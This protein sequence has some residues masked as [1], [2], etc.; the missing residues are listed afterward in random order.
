MDVQ[1]LDSELSVD[2]DVSTDLLTEDLFENSQLVGTNTISEKLEETAVLEL[3]DAEEATHVA[4]KSGSWFDPSTWQN[5]EVPGANARIVIPEG[6]AVDYDSVSTA[7]LFSL[8]VDGEISFSPE[9]DTQMVIDTFVISPLGSLNIGSENNPIQSG[10]STKIII[11]DNGPIDTLWDPNQLS[12]GVISLGAVNIHGQLKTPF[13]PIEMAPA[14]GDSSLVLEAIPEDWQVGDVLVIAASRQAGTTETEEESVTIQAIA[15]NRITLDRPLQFDHAPDTEALE[16]YVANISR[17]VVIETENA[18]SLPVHQRGHVLLAANDN[19]DVRFAEFRELGRTDYSKPFDSTLIDQGDRTNIPGRYALQLNQ[20]GNPDADSPAILMGNSIV[21]SPGLG[22][23]QF[24]SHAVLEGNAAY[25]VIGAGFVAGTDQESGSWLNNIALK[26]ET[27]YSDPLAQ[28]SIANVAADFW[29]QG[30]IAS[31]GNISVESPLESGTTSVEPAL[32]TASLANSTVNSSVNVTEPLSSAAIQPAVMSMQATVD[33]LDARN[34]EMWEFEEW[35]LNNSTYSGNPF[36]LKAS[37]TFTHTQSGE[38][39]TTNMFY[40]GG[41]EWSFRFTGDLA[42]EWRFETDSADKDLDGFTGKINVSPNDNPEVDGFLTSV[43]NKFALQTDDANT[44]E[45]YLLN[46]YMN[47]ADH[48]KQGE[49]TKWDPSRTDDYLADARNNGSEV[50][51]FQVNNNWFDFGSEKNSEHNSRNPDERTFELL[52][53]VITDVHQQGGRVHFW[54]WGD[55][56]RGWTPIDGVNSEADQRLQS[57]IAARLGPL[58]GWSMGYSFDTQEFTDDND[59]EFWADN[60]LS[61]MGWDHLLF[62]RGYAASSDVPVND[63]TSKNDWV[64]ENLSGHSYSS[65]GKYQ[66]GLQTSPV[67]PENIEEVIEDINTETSKPHF[68]EE[69]F[70]YNRSSVGST[71]GGPNDMDQTRQLMWWQAMAG[72]VGGWFGFFDW[73]GNE[74]PPYSNPEQLRTHYTFWHENDRFTLDLE[75]ANN[76]ADSSDTHLLKTADDSR[77]IVYTENRDSVQVD[78]PQLVDDSKVIAVDTKK[79]YREIDLGAIAEGNNRQIELPYRSDWAIVIE[80]ETRSGGGSTPV[81]PPEVPI[82]PPEEPEVPETPDEPEVPEVP[83]TPTLPSEDPILWWTLDEGSGSNADDASGNNRDG[84][85]SSGADWT[86]EGQINGALRLDGN[87]Q[88]VINADAEDYLNGLDAITVSMWVKSD[89]VGSDRGFLSTVDKVGDDKDLGIR[90]DDR[91]S[92]GGGD[93]V[94]K[95]GLRTTEGFVEYESASNV[96]T[97]A[98]QHIVLSWNSGEAPKLYINGQLDNPTYA[99]PAIGGTLS[100]ITDLIVGKGQRVEES[101]D[102]NIDDVRIYNR[103]VSAA[104]VMGLFNDEGAPANRVPV[105]AADTY[106]ATAGEPLTVSAEEGVLT[107]DTDA[108]GDALSISNSAT[109]SD[110]G[111]NVA[112]NADGSF[113]YTPPADF[114][115]DDSFDYTVSDGKGGSQTAQVTVEVAAASVPEDPGTPEEPGTPEPPMPPIAEPIL[116]WTLDEG[117]GSNADDASGNNRDGAVSSG[118]DWTAEGQINGALRLDGNQQL[119]INADAEDYLNGLDAITVSMWVKSDQVG[120]DRGFLSTVDKVGDDKDLGIRYDDRG[121][122][123]GGDDVIKLGLRTTEGFVEYES[124]SNVQTQAWQHIV[125]SWNSG[126]APKL[127]INGQLDNPT[128]AAP[129]IGGTLS[130]ITDLIVGKGQR[131]EES[132]DGNIDDVRIY[133]RAVN[134]EEAVELFNLGDMALLP[135]TPPVDEPSEP[136]DPTTP[137]L[138]DDPDFISSLERK[139]RTKDLDALQ[140][141]YNVAFDE[142][143]KPDIHVGMAAEDVVLLKVQQNEMTGTAREKS[144][145]VEE[146]FDFDLTKNNIE[147]VGPNGQTFRPTAVH[148]KTK[149]ADSAKSYKGFIVDHYFHIELP[150]ALDADQEYT[151]RFTEGNLETINFTPEENVS[152]AIHHARVYD[153]STE[154]KF[155]KLSS[156]MSTDGGGVDYEEGTPYRVIDEATGQVVHSGGIT[157]DAADNFAGTDVYTLDLSSVKEIGTYRIEVEGIGKSLPFEVR[158]NVWEDMLDLTMEGLYVHRAFAE[159]EEPYTD[160]VRPGNPDIV[161]YPSSVSEVDFDFFDAG[162]EFEVLPATADRS[163]P[164]KLTGGWFD[165]GDYDTKSV[166]LEAVMSLVDLYNSAP[167]YFQSFDPNIPESGDHIPD[168]LNEAMWGMQLYKQLQQPHGGVSAGYEFDSHPSGTRSW[169]E[170]EAFIYAPDFRS[171]YRFAAA[172]SKLSTAL[173]PF[174]AAEAADLR[175]RAIRAF[176]WAEQEFAKLPASFEYQGKADGY[177][178]FASV[179]MYRLTGDKDY[180]DIFRSVDEQRNYRAS[181]VYAQL[182]PEVYTAVDEEWQDRLHQRIIE[183]ADKLVRYGEENGF[184][185]INDHNHT[186]NWGYNTVITNVHSLYMGMAHQLTGDAKYLNALADS[187]PFG[188]GMNPDN[189]SFTT[190]TVELGLAYDEVDDVLHDDGQAMDHIPDGITVYGFYGNGWFAW[191]TVNGAT[192]NVVFN[193]ETKTL[194]VPFIEAFNDYRMM[195]PMTEYTIHQTIDEQIYANGYLAAHAADQPTPARTSDAL[196][197]MAMSAQIAGDTDTDDLLTNYAGATESLEETGMEPS[198]GGNFSMLEST[199]NISDVDAIALT[200]IGNNSGEESEDSTFGDGLTA[201]TGTS[202]LEVDPMPQSVAV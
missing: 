112:L 64:A 2:M 131:V 156:W 197:G 78:L 57:Y 103:A 14:A 186:Q 169:E 51:Y 68:Y 98:W 85:V 41:N 44:L 42:G 73:D 59:M 23:V 187:M 43:G 126:E 4:V 7:P 105:A 170:V 125:L 12:R 91:G 40:D 123:G 82:D 124:A 140:E 135:E 145:F 90:Y 46:V 202:P 132:W 100:G 183:H 92:Y 191:E 184:D 95:L 127:Y 134:A 18:G 67:S 16:T 148:R 54:A 200:S 53:Q 83:E 149:I 201:V 143:G 160:F 162:K 180:H 138:D 177:R 155:A 81:P 94:I 6:I 120:S 21:G 161:F 175:E 13:L 72:G 189:M 60:L 39:R 172:A 29:P 99:A 165:A 146:S 113:E 199:T 101:W 147:I 111:G 36:D 136:S 33:S 80:S 96:Q 38:Q 151:V 130:G 35:D 167:D 9:M 178:Q 86:A 49:L 79:N 87:Q 31:D 154:N 24:D 118:A 110:Q 171:S 89:Q 109:T 182:D 195:V 168:V 70:T 128:Y 141:V 37:V 144:D 97:Q 5:G 47:Q 26:A 194:E 8:R 93:D 188:M 166:H 153:A 106:A 34:V 71:P 122:Y 55:R 114:V 32:E 158:E 142:R 58:P 56:A 119:V 176:D 150:E 20:V 179:E 104:E 48:F 157:L 181:F 77:Y 84:A 27:A 102:G 62:A 192:D 63:S 117:S 108:D 45:G 19:V 152:L 163:K 22:Y 17:N 129:A 121:S 28:E 193:S 52:E 69:R 66:E 173:E 75:Q 190:G 115:G 50:L 25:D 164:T 88:L 61:Q 198:A 137:V 76:L 10:V 196:T 133:K 74:Q 11:A 65:K 1:F 30:A 174:D 107:N 139:A 185:T 15:G 159:L 3:V 116:W